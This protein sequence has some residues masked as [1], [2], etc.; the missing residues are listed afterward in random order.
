MVMHH[1]DRWGSPGILCNLFRSWGKE[2]RL[3]LDGGKKFFTVGVVRHW[4][5][6]PIEA[7]I[8]GSVQGMAGWG[9]EQPGLG[10]GV[11]VNDKGV[12]TW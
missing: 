8:P 5:K 10:K 3:G 12:R 6:L 9:L 7:V 4:N 11:P 1:T 2:S